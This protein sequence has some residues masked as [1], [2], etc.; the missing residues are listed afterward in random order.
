MD[1]FEETDSFSTLVEK[2]QQLRAQ[3]EQQ[4]KLL[5]HEDSKT[6][7]CV[8]TNFAIPFGLIVIFIVMLFCFNTVNVDDCGCEFAADVDENEISGAE[9]LFCV[10]ENIYCYDNIEWK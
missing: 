1:F 7:K 10:T 8:I 3:Q 5:Q 4:T 9:Y 2:E 6:K